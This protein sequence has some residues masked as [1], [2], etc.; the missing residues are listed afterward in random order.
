MPDKHTKMQVW[1]HA[2]CVLLSSD[3]SQK[4][5]G[6]CLQSLANLIRVTAYI[7]KIHSVAAENGK[8]DGTGSKCPLYIFVTM[9]TESA[10]N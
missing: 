10:L 2:K 8:T 3:F 4:K 9:C 6:I 5:K 7:M 1:I